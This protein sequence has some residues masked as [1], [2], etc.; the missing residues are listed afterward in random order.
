MTLTETLPILQAIADGEPWQYRR[1]NMWFDTISSQDPVNLIKCGYEIRLTPKPEKW[2][3]EKAAHAAG[4]KIEMWSYITNTWVHM[5]NPVWQGNAYRIAPAPTYIPLGPEDV[6]PGSV[7]RFNR[8]D[9]WKADALGEWSSVV[10]V[11]AKYGIGLVVENN[12]GELVFISW[13]SAMD[14]E[15]LRPGETEWKLCRKEKP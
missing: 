5:P 15:I 7:F 4:K 2:A 12:G 11:S 3:A 13:S 10:N 6:P 1:A 14:H 9:E 8:N